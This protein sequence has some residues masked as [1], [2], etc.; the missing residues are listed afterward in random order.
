MDVV[1][2]TPFGPQK[3]VVPVEEVAAKAGKAAVEA[4]WPAVQQHV[5]AEIPT[6]VDR[7]LEAAQPKLRAEVDRAVNRVTLHAGLIAVGLSAVVLM[8]GSWVRRAFPD[9]R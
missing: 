6:V 3:F 5:Y 9:R 2:D 7:S 8:T 1:I 4:A